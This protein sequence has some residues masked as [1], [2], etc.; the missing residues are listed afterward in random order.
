[1]E[2]QTDRIN[3][4][5]VLWLDLQQAVRRAGEAAIFPWESKDKEVVR[6]W[7]QITDSKN[8]CALEEWL[9]QI[10]PGQMERW[11]QQALLESRSRGKI[12]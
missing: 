7:Q 11:A 10:A 9:F 6:L 3:R 1:M 4:L 5:L 12:S 8:Q 2:N